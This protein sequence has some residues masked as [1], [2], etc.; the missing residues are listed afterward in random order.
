MTNL[1]PDLQA[2]LLCED[3]R[4]EIN[5]MQT[6]VGVITALPFPQLPA[7]LIKLCV[8]SRWTGGQGVFTQQSRI[9][10]PDEETEVGRSEVRFELKDIDGN[11]TNVHYFGG[12]VFHVQGP[13]TIEILLDGELQ[14]RF[15][16]PVVLVSGPQLASG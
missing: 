10:A 14:L 11:A 13:H 8:W 1:T 5:G 6:L 12:L 3:V 9:L 7:R 15:V 16:I 4:Q 2:A